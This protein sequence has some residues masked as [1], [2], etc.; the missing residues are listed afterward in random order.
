MPCLDPRPWRY[1]FLAGSLAAGLAG[2]ALLPRPAPA[3]VPVLQ[4]AAPLQGAGEP[5]LVVFLPGRGD[6]PEDFRR[7]GFARLARERG[8]RCEMV[9]VDAHLGYYRNR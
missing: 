2:C 3:P 6:R 7:H 8:V 9:A 5:C 4:L 1:R